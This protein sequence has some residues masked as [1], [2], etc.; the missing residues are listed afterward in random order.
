MKRFKFQTVKECALIPTF[1]IVWT[2]CDCKFS[3]AF[4]WLNVRA[5]VMCFMY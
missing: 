2:G 1:G 3:I 5:C 4:A